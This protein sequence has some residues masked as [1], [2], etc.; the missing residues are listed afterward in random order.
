MRNFMT[1]DRFRYVFVAYIVYASVK[2]LLA[3]PQLAAAHAAA[4][5]GLLATHLYALALVEILAAVGLLL[6]RLVSAATV[7]LLAVFAVA[8]VMDLSLGEAPVHLLLYAAITVLLLPAAAVP[9][10]GA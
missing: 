1:L 4:H 9:R 3:A 6:P 5:A 8:A 2:T 10:A 7:L